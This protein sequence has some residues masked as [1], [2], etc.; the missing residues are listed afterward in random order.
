MNSNDSRR[1][2]FLEVLGVAVLL[3]G[4]VAAAAWYFY[5]S[6]YLLYY[7]D[8]QAHLNISRSWMDGRQ[9]GY[10]QLGTVWLPVLHLIC[11]PFAAKDHL[12]QSGLAGTIPVGA[13]FIVAGVCFYLCGKDAFGS[14]LAALTG[15]LCFA[16]N[17]NV[18]YLATITMTEL[19][20]VAGLL[21]CLLSILWFGK[22]Q[23]TRW[24]ALAVVASWWMSLTRYDGWFLIPFIALFLMAAAKQGKATVLFVSGALASLAPIY[25]MAHN[26]WETGNALDF[27]NGPYS[28]A[29]IQGDHPYPGFHDWPAAV[30]YY[31]EAGRVCSGYGLIAA[32]VLGMLVAI[33]KGRLKGILF[34]ALTPLFYVWSVHSS[35]T[36]IYLPSLWPHG[37]YNSRY[38]I[39]VVV[40]MA[41]AAGALASALPSRIRLLPLLSILPWVMWP[42]P[43]NWICWK[44]SQR[45]SDSRRAWTAQ[46][47]EY[48]DRYYKRGDGVLVEF[49]DMAGI[50]GK[51]GLPLKEALHEGSGPAWFVNTMPNG[52][53]RQTKWA[54][55][56]KDD[57]LARVLEQAK[58]FH[59]VDV[60][61]VEG[62]PQLLIY[63][64]N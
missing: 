28:A 22:T 52:L 12:W 27:Y 9:T 57:K 58:S 7:G 11:L 35:K 47:A 56:Q 1:S 59:V 21:V 23:H 33:G 61:R 16:L 31:W 29:A 60:I 41:F 45:N 19:V 49:G 4:I 44:E 50:F 54:I 15:V 18:L 62:A 32:G 42:S 30:H 2:S 38:G 10:D 51:A 55:A 46:A 17:P 43:E 25:W 13:C 39:A 24:A 20:F 14:S 34:L 63:E 6:G 64:R 5:S 8:A 48:L 40:F 37:Y 53:V 3:G 36:P 26:W